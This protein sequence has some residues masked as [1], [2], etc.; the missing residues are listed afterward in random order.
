MQKR[1]MQIA[2]LFGVLSFPSFAS[3]DGGLLGSTLS[4]P[5]EIVNTVT[6]EVANTTSQ[7][8]KAL[9]IKT[10]QE[11]SLQPVTEIVNNVTETTQKVTKAVKSEEPIVEVK[12]STS[13]SVKVNTGVVEAKVSQTPKVKVDTS[14]AKVEVADT[15]KVDTEV[16]QAEV[17][18]DPQISVKTPVVDVE[19]SV[20]T[21]STDKEI[22]VTPVPETEVTELPV[23]KLKQEVPLVMKNKKEI[24]KPDISKQLIIDEE[25][26][27]AL[28]ETSRNERSLN[29]ET[30]KPKNALPI[31][32]KVPINYEQVQA[33]PTFQSGPSTLSNSSLTMGS[34]TFAVLDGYDVSNQNGTMAYFGK[35]R[36]FF[37]QWLNAPPS[38]PPQQSPLKISR[39]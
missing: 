16:V 15:V 33:T 8:E 17:E 7:V 12:D 10:E 29:V 20:P 36:L 1:M 28:N 4:Q 34:M 39:I 19:S 14:I 31:P 2:V 35:T 38:Q 11:E 22:R 37:D 9:P 30:D 24:V 25:Q 23:E 3:A 27:D 13:P 5:T 6:D 26:D 18:R 32:M 21:Q